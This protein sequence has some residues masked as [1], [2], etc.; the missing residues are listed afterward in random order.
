MAYLCE[1][2]NYKINYNTNLKKT[3]KKFC[4]RPVA[5]NEKKCFSSG[6]AKGRNDY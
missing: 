3:G 5:K 2:K 1:I 6:S 4:P